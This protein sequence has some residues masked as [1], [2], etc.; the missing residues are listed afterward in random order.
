MDNII[1]TGGPMRRNP[2]PALFQSSN[3]LKV[4]SFLTDHPGQAYLSSEILGALSMSRAGIYLAL[5][6]LVA[7]G[8]ASRTE[9]GRFHL[10][11]VDP[12][13]PQV[14]LF[15]VLKNTVL[16]EPLL[17]QLRSL[18]IKIILFGS[19]GRGED[20]SS[21]DIDLFILTRDPEN[22]ADILSSFSCERKIQPVVIVPA[23]WRGFREKNK[24]FW[25]EI[26]RGFV[27]WEERD[28]PGVSRP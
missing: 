13:H 18:S 7:G 9:R 15:K 19:A 2:L 8:F 1:D 23:Q 11:S 21:S 6:E 25:G 14:K 26:D 28:E 22:I 16:I 17:S 10:Y 27:L 3:T 12:V 4:L 20:S 24:V 5:Q